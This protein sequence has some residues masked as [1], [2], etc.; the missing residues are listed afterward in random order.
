GYIAPAPTFTATPPSS[1]AGGAETLLTSAGAHG[2]T[3]AEAVGKHLYIASGT[4]WSTGFYEITEIAEDTTGTTIQIDVPFDAGFG[5]PTIALAG[6]EV[7]F[8]TLTIPP[9][10]ADSYIKIDGTWSITGST[11]A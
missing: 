2:L 5:T 7:T 3:G 4:G 1:A 8:T 10:R 9:L 11:T 6:T